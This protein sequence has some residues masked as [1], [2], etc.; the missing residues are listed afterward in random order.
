MVGDCPVCSWHD[1]CLY[2]GVPIHEYY[3]YILH[4]VHHLRIVING[5]G[6]DPGVGDE[7]VNAGGV[8]EAPVLADE[9]GN[10]AEDP[11]DPRNEA[12]YSYLYKTVNH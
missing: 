11:R 2:R 12:L 9:G 3:P 8:V 6:G 10:E 5:G 7:A 1:Y 4:R